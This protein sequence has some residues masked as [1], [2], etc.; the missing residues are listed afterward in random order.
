ML[1]TCFFMRLSKKFNEFSGGH[2]EG[3]TPVPIPNTV[4]KPLSVDGTTL[5]TGRE[6]RSLPGIKFSSRLRREENLF[7]VDGS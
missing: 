7:V 3:E 2:S 4:V 6:S 1:K 5:E